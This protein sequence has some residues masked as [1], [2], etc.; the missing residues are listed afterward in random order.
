MSCKFLFPSAVQYDA[1]VCVLIC[2]NIHFLL[3]QGCL[4]D[5]GND[6]FCKIRRG[7]IVSVLPVALLNPKPIPGPSSSKDTAVVVS[8]SRGVGGVGGDVVSDGEDG[9]DGEDHS[10]YRAYVAHM[11]ELERITPSRILKTPAERKWDKENK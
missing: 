7:H 4:V 3:S 1:C 2:S 5:H 11:T 9:E 10:E 6:K 8:S